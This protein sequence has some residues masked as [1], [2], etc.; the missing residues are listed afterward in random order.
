VLVTWFAQYCLPLD[1][2]CVVVT[3]CV[4]D[5]TLDGTAVTLCVRDVTLDGIPMTL[6]FRDFALNHRIVQDVGLL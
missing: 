3:L 4:R 2:C 6:G 1:S 5:V